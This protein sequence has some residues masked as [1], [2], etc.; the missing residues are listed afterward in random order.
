MKVWRVE[1]W[2]GEG[3]SEPARCRVG[4]WGKTLGYHRAAPRTVS[5]FPRVRC[6]R[7][8][9]VICIFA[10]SGVRDRG[11]HSIT[12]ILFKI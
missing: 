4:E 8:N 9:G 11:K 12:T 1:G 10:I 5:L 3:L 6:R 7:R 2:A